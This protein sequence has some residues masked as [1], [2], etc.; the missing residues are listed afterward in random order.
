[1]NHVEI[2]VYS[3]VLLNNTNKYKNIENVKN[4][5]VFPQIKF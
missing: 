2:K 3:E 1:M 4:W 5:E